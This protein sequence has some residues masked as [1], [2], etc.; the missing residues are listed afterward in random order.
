MRHLE[1]LALRDIAEAM[2]TTP[3]AV[4]GLIRRGLDAMRLQMGR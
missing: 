1:G 4:A 2:K 3:G